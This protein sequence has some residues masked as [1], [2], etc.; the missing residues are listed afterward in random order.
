MAN[1]G[2]FGSSE[3][4]EYLLIHAGDVTNEHADGVEIVQGAS[5]SDV[6][7]LGQL[8]SGDDDDDDHG[9]RGTKPEQLNRLAL[10]KS[11]LLAYSVGHFYNDLCASMWFV[12]LLIFLEKVVLLYS[13]EAGLL[14]LIGQVADAVSTPLIGLLSDHSILP[15][16]LMRF[17]RR[18]SWHVIGTC[19]VTLSF[20][21]I[22]SGCLLC[23]KL[24]WLSNI[25]I[26]WFILPIV[27]FQ[28]GWAAVQI[29]HLA[30][31]PELTTV[32]HTRMSMTS[33]RYANTV[34]ANLAIFVLLFVFLRSDAQ[35]TIGPEDLPYF[36]N[37]ALIT[38]IVGLGVTAIFYA[39]I[40]EP[41]ILSQQQGQQ[42]QQ[43]EIIATIN[44]QQKMKW[45]DWFRQIGFYQTAALYLFARLYI[46]ISQVY[47][48]FYI[49]Q[50]QV[51][52]KTDIALLPLTAFIASFLVSLFLS[53]SSISKRVN[54]K[55]LCILGT[56]FGLSNCILIYTVHQRSLLMYGIASLLGVVQAILLIASLNTTATLINRSTESS[57]FV[58]GA[59]SFLDKFSNG[60][61]V[62]IVELFNPSCHHDA[63]ISAECDHFYRVVMSAIPGACVLIIF[64]L[65]LFM[66]LRKLGQR[67]GS[68]GGGIESA[69]ASAAL[70]AGTGEQNFETQ[71]TN[72]PNAP[73]TSSM[74]SS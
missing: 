36:R 21:F 69:N 30:L 52:A 19:C 56:F 25:K 9:D 70:I 64:A 27:A 3:S 42:Q 24:H 60:L 43:L 28:F 37:L 2:G 31:I 16:F 8:I 72:V 65:I 73:T 71:D 34:M 51:A 44:Q 13:W 41:G 49:T 53:L 67:D 7:Q 62:Q 14:M 18:K 15:Q 57:A 5:N 12:Y 20:P 33:L 58:Y 66:D 32:E 23:G 17:G 74:P 48:S 22:F 47:F 39:G 61:I 38:I 35:T 68:G 63:K 46:N 6:E 26:V 11:K 40:R 4:R 54:N 55:F 50:S 10:P 29:S 59:M 1:N 45:Y